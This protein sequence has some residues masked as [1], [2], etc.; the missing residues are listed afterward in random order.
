MHAVEWRLDLY[1]DLA[2]EVYASLYEYDNTGHGTMV[3]DERFGPFDT[4]TD[5]TN[6]VLRHWGPRAKLPLH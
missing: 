4:A 1:K 2:G 3:C 5:V 6:W